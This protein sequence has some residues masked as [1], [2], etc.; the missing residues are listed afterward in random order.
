MRYFQVVACAG[1]EW[2]SSLSVLRGEYTEAQALEVA[3]KYWMA[4]F[5]PHS[6]PQEFPLEPSVSVGEISDT[7]FEVLVKF[8]VAEIK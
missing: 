5:K 3:T 4:K 6:N 1:V 7:Q 2:G 8:K